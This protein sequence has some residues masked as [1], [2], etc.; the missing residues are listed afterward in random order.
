MIDRS[1][2][3]ELIVRQHDTKVRHGCGDTAYIV[4]VAS[5]AGGY[6][7]NIGRYMESCAARC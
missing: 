4:F 7:V 1:T 5:G 3:G 2:L 6:G